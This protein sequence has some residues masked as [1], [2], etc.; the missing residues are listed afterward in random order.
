MT[1]MSGP[2]GNKPWYD[3]LLVVSN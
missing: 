3:V 1:D 2:D